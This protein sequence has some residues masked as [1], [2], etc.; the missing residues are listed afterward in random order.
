MPVYEYY[1]KKCDKVYEFI[2]KIND[3]PKSNCEV[4]NGSLHKQISLS[5][6]QLKGSGWYVTDYGKGN[7]NGA[8]KQSQKEDKITKTEDKSTKPESK[9]KP[10]AKKTKTE[11]KSTAKAD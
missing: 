7:G 8:D 10:T 1:C 11:T 5:S 2:Q 9:E 6:F 3:K 4:C